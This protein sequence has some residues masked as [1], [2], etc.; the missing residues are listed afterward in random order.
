[1]N[2]DENYS[3]DTIINFLCNYLKT[4][5]NEDLE[6]DDVNVSILHYHYFFIIIFYLNILKY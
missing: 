5:W 1:M 4:K 6:D 2:E 3:S